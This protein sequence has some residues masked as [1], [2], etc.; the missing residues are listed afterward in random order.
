MLYTALKL[1]G[2]KRLICLKIFPCLAQYNMH[3]WI[4]KGGEAVKAFVSVVAAAWSLMKQPHVWLKAV[5]LHM[6]VGYTV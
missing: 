1:L 4:A 2:S 6:C 3:T 5:A